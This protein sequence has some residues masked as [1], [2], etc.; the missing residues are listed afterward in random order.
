MSQKE[1][2]RLYVIQSAA[3]EKCTVRQ[4]AGRLTLSTRRIKQMKKEFILR[5]ASAVIHGNANRSSPK[6][7]QGA[8]PRK[9][10]GI[11]S[12]GFTDCNFTHFQEILSAR[13]GIEIAYTSPH[14]LLNSEGIKSP[15]SGRKKRKV[16]K[17]R[18][19]YP[20]EG[21]LLQADATPFAWFGGKEKFSLHGF[22]DDATGKV[23]GAC[24]CR[25]ERLPGY[26][27]ALRQTLTSFGIP[28]ALSPDRYGV[29]F[30]NP[31]KEDD[32]SIEEQLAGGTKKTTQFG[33]IIDRLGIDM[34]PA[35]SAQAKGR[36][37][38]LRN[39]LQS[40]L[41]VEL[42]M[43]GVTTCEEANSFLLEYLPR[44]NRQFGAEPKESFSAYVPVP[45]TCDPDRLLSVESTRS[46]SRGSTISI[47][48]KTFMIDQ[49]TFPGR[50]KVTLLLS[51]KHGLRA[52]INGVFYPIRCL[53]E[54]APAPEGPV[55]TGELPG[56][57][58][59]LLNTYLLKESKAS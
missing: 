29:F 32:L 6:K 42:R 28:L 12:Q 38:R 53:S 55:R 1:L 24:I 40:R 35:R 57:V 30:I 47:S 23:T 8:L 4:A 5:G 51:E 10:A 19:R 25:N 26:L 48:N 20:A 7:L 37:E 54:L 36:I 14:R 21:M 17:T 59:D 58:L 49:D 2:M 43:A 52:L 46:L 34:F 22:V 44:F 18:E 50:T 15:K 56:V 33:R 45:S 41:P 16:H 13:F 39:T 31:K 27:E 11:Y 3:E 9:I